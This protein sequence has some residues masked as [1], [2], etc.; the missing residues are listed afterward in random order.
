M[1]G[2]EAAVAVSLFANDRG[3]SGIGRYLKS[4]VPCLVEAM[5]E[6]AFHLFAARADLPVFAGCFER[7]GSRVTWHTSST[8]WNRPPP[9]LFWHA[10]RWDRAARRAGA[11]ALYLPAGNRRLAPFARLPSVAVVHDLSWLHM[12]G[13]YDPLREFYLRRLLPWMIRRSTRIIAISQSTEDDLVRL[14]HCPPQQIVR[15]ANGFDATAFHP[16]DTA[17]SRGELQRDGVRLPEH[18]LLY[19]SR[20]E[21]PGKNHVNLLAAYR[22]LLDRRPALAEHLV[23]AGGRWNGAEAIDAAIRDLGL[24]D[25]VHCLGF[26][27]DRHLPMLYATA[28]ALV[29]PSLFEGFGLPVIEAQACGLAVAGADCSSIPEVMGGAGLLFDPLDPESIAEAIATL[30]DHP[31]RRAELAR[32]GIENARSYTWEATA[33]ATARL[34]R[35]VIDARRAHTDRA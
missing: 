34:L 29:F 11:D 33:A 24:G 27:A 18:F 12:R 13:K 35:E 17:A 25:R 28:T 2:T 7:F 21:H 14:A 9:S 5:P 1:P 16:R 10:A 32:R 8:F 20:L 19:V 26:V 15:I 6:A 4:V 3:T 22:R 30:V 23:F 31:D